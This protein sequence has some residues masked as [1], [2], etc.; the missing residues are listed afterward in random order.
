MTSKP[1]AYLI[2]PFFGELHWEYFR[3]S[4]YVIHLKKREPDIQIVVMTRPERFDFYGKYADVLVPLNIK[5]DDMYSQQAF[6]LIGFDNNIANELCDIFRISYKKKYSI[7]KHIVPDFL[8]FRYKIKWQ[9]P[10]DCMDYDFYPRK[11]NIKSINNMFKSKKI[12]IADE[13]YT[14]KTEKY[15]VIDI[16]NLKKW[17]EPI[18]ENKKVTYYGCL[19]HLLKRSKFVISNL[20]SDVGRLA[21][22]LNTIL[23]Y[24]Y[25]TLTN[26]QVFLL[27]PLN[28]PIIDCDSIIE[29]VE[30]YENNF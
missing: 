20:R 8:S 21:I 28:T 13:G 24:P 15:N 17:I 4:P 12:V 19:I 23:I 30:F 2:G 11:S 7:V 5:N 6:K 27:N 10:R 26:D 22:L 25:R 1:K 9:F 16:K 18:S 3:F 29:G 14:Y